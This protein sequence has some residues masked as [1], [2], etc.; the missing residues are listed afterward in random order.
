MLC[1]NKCDID[2]R[3][4]TLLCRPDT[5]NIQ[6]YPTENLRKTRYQVTIRWWRENSLNK[7]V[8][9]LATNQRWMCMKAGPHPTCKNEGNSL[10]VTVFVINVWSKSHK[11]L[12][13]QTSKVLW[14]M[15]LASTEFW[16]R[17]S[18]Q[19]KMLAT[20]SHWDSYL[21]A[22]ILK[23]LICQRWYKGWDLIME[24]LVLHDQPVTL[25]EDKGLS[26]FKLK[27]KLQ[28]NAM[29]FQTSVLTISL[30]KNQC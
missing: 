21:L 24:T 3:C 22:R 2:C 26:Y 11:L 9:L 5:L 28:Y 10:L 25:F 20:K 16:K 14:N 27:F 23:N 29:H 8:Q 6:R 4:Q 15:A 12:I 1:D 18:V 30:E 19:L 7:P 13:L 17:I